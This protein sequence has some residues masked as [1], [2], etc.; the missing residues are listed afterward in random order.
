MAPVAH[1]RRD[2]DYR[3]ERARAEGTDGS[4]RIP[5]RGEAGS[6]S[7]SYMHESQHGRA[8]PLRG[9]LNRLLDFELTR[10]VGCHP[11]HGGVG[12]RLFEFSLEPPPW[13][14]KT[15][16]MLKALAQSRETWGLLS[17]N[18]RTRLGDPSGAVRGRRRAGYR[19]AD[20]NGICHHTPA[21]RG[22][23]LGSSLGTCRE[24]RTRFSH[25]GAYDPALSSSLRGKLA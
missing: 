9:R 1:C 10:G 7:N 11:S 4:F 3:P 20:L 19:L 6:D 12:S 13:S 5:G 16:P 2:T 21:P 25:G 22:F 14:L 18:I 17:S 24:S 8:I 15:S 23:S